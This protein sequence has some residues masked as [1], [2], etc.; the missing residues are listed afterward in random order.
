[1][2]YFFKTLVTLILLNLF[3]PVYA[4]T[5][6]YDPVTGHL[7]LP[8]VL[9]NGH[10]YGN[11]VL[12]LGSDGRYQLLSSTS[13]VSLTDADNGRSIELVPGQFLE[14]KLASNPSTGYSWTFNAQSI[15][16]VELQGNSS[17]VLDSDCEGRVGCGGSETGKFKVVKQGTGTLRLEYRRPWETTAPPA[18]VFQLS[19]TVR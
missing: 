19:I 18:Q 11:I 5:P 6:S 14:I 17:F 2:S 4:A 13:P 12:A 8:E 3:A 15:D 9:I 1:M 10:S 16:L 7:N